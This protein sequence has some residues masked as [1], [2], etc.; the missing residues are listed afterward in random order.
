[1]EFHLEWFLD[2]G[3]DASSEIGFKVSGVSD[4]EAGGGLDG[5]FGLH[6][7]DFLHALDFPEDDDVSVVQSVLLLVMEAH[8]A[9]FLLGDACDMDAFSFFSVGVKDSMGLSEIDE[10][11]AVET[12]VPCQNETDVLAP[13]GLVEFDEIVLIVVVHDHHALVIGSTKWVKG[14]IY[15]MLSSYT[16]LTFTFGFRSLSSL[17]EACALV[18]LP[19][20]SS[21]A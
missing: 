19:T 20:C 16:M 11:V 2:L 3:G 7:V 12:Q 4:G 14:Y 13:A 21:F 17:T 8:Q 10:G 15:S 5:D 18:L 9:Y 6:V 1:M